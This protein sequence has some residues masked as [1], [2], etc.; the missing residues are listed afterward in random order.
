M[1][2]KI[3]VCPRCQGSGVVPASGGK[4]KTCP[5]CNGT[6]SKVIHTREDRKWKQIDAYGVLIILKKYITIIVSVQK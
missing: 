2:Q 3:I 1:P 6:G 4:T 5:S